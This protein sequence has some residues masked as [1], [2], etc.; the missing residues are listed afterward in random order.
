[1]AQD[2]IR[3]EYSEIMQKSFIDYSMSVIL[4]RA[5]PD[6]RDGLK[7]VQRRTLYDMYEL[8][9]DY[10]K[11]YKKSARIVGDTMGKYHPH[12]D[13]SIYESLV[14][15]SQDFK[16]SLPLVDGHGNF[17]SI[18]GDGAAAMRYT[19]ARLAKVAQEVY[20]G[21]L[22]KNVVD[23]VP[24]YDE[25]EKEPEVLPVRVP[26]I[27]ING[28][29]GIAV[30]MVTSIPQH[31][32]GEVVDGVIAYMKD[33]D[34][35]TAQMLSIISGPDFPTGGIITNK[36]DLMEI[37]STGVGKI[38]IRGKAEIEK[39]K[40]GKEQIVI[41]EIPYTMIGANIGKFLNDI[42]SLVE[43]KKTN[44]ITDISNQS[45]GEQIRIIVEL[46]KGADAQNVLNL[47]YKKT[48]LEDTFG[49]NM[50]AVA[51]G[52]PET[53]GIVPII[54]HHVNFQYELC[55]RK[56]THLLGKEREKKEIQEGLIKACDVIDLIIEILRGSKDVKQAKACLV[57]GIT[58][59]IKFKSEQSKKDAALLKFTERQAQAILD[60]RL[61]RL[62]GL[63][64][65]ALRGDYAETMQKI[66]DY[67]KILGSRAEMAKVIIKDL[68][69]IKKE[70]ARERRTVIDNVEEA[71]VEE[72]PIEVIDVAVL[73]DRFAYARVID[74]PTFER[75]KDAA[76]TE[77]KKIVFC[78]NVDKICLFTEKGD[79]HAIKVLSLPFGKFRD[80]GQPIDTAEKGSKIDLTKEN[81]IF[82]D[83]MENIKDKK[84]IFGTKQG[85]IK[86]VDGSEFD[87]SRKLIAATK[88]NDKD[89]VICV[90]IL[91]PTD[92]VVMQSDKDMFLR[93]D[94]AT[95]PEKK[96][97]A[98]GVRGMKL[99]KGDFLTQIH[100]LA[101]GEA[102]DV[103]V[104]GKAV[105]L[106]R[107]H[108]G[109]RDTK[110]VK[111]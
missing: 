30:G 13:S 19:E 2:I 85:M 34:I 64:I 10:N 22:D 21:D 60:M 94:G 6:V 63:E 98:V 67:N 68:Q 55:T 23:F 102:K 79:M 65:E 3:T 36:D 52:K 61:H 89:E 17:G 54:R 32:L 7:P 48:R 1:M 9:V 106:N 25:T 29:D 16:K 105:A 59:G 92:T 31:N 43:T 62:I 111:K 49:V 104:K 108:V 47:L 4:A 46:R 84:L 83:A 103:K 107:L 73:I 57:E 56:Y 96:K 40:G 45:K 99:A 33:P 8:K 78:K 53:L 39:I 66:S 88:L 101:E 69:A 12:G 87:V 71:V 72:K 81:L 42:Y 86:V 20:L 77:S 97:T 74:M 51:D 75:N 18:E 80:K 28:S 5:V 90:K 50:L 70:Y 11:P 14:V 44:D 58:D 93:I 38:K 76:E 27:L 109:T 37:Y 24:N 82:A 26:N 15:M 91:E 41:T 110:G 35:N 100:V 95:I